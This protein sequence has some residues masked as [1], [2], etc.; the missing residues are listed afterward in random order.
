VAD[1]NGVDFTADGCGPVNLIDQSQGAGWV[2]DAEGTGGGEDTTAIEPRFIIVELPAA[3]DV[4]QLTINPSTSCGL[5]GSASTGDFKVETSPDGATWTL[6]AQGHFGPTQRTPQTVA[7]AAGS[8]ADVQFVR[9]WMLGT[10]TAD[11]GGSCPGNFSGCTYVVSSELAVY[12]S[13]AS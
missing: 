8:T 6:G 4:A 11:I 3:V 7:L 5:G 13:P 12:G 9:Y 2:S 1:F 10:Q